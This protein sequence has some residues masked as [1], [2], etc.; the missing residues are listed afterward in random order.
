MVHVVE[1]ERHRSHGRGRPPSPSLPLSADQQPVGS[2]APSFGLLPGAAAVA[3]VCLSRKDP[4]ELLL[5]QLRLTGWTLDRQNMR[6]ERRVEVENGELALSLSL[7][8][9]PLLAQI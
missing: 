4:L 6:G 8:L 2:L 3:L 7:I 5:L 9:I 1:R